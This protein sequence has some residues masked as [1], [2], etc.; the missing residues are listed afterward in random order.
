MCNHYRV[1]PV[2][3]TRPAW[4]NYPGQR[5]QK[6]TPVKSRKVERAI[7]LTRAQT[8]SR[9]P[10]SLSPTPST[11]NFCA[12]RRARKIT[13]KMQTSRSGVQPGPHTEARARLHMHA[14][15][16]ERGNARARARAVLGLFSEFKFAGA[17]AIS[18]RLVGGRGAGRATR[19]GEMECLD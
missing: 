17:H 5:C 9:A 10:R 11:G 15:L 12:Q 6:Q 19:P 13:R 4:P 18:M 8:S 16:F 7:T 3:I 1:Y 14:M 2:S